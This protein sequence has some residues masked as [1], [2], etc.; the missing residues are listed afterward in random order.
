MGTNISPSSMKD[1]RKRSLVGKEPVAMEGVKRSRVMRTRIGN[2]DCRS[3]PAGIN[4][5]NSLE[6]SRLGERLGNLWPSVSPKRG[7]E[8]SL[9]I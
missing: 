2:P 9:S 7:A 3:S 1:G 8:Y 6:L 5:A 4:E